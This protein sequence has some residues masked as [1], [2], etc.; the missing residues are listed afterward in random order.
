[1]HGNQTLTLGTHE[2][3][4][5]IPFHILISVFRAT[6]IVPVSCIS[7]L[8]EINLAELRQ[9]GVVTFRISTIAVFLVFFLAVK[10]I[11]LIA[12]FTVKS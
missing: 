12:E 7:T 6:R 1:M 8:A 9:F 4:V 11:N 5:A 10:L 3:V 2:I